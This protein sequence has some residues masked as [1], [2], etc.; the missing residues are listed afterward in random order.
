M[1]TGPSQSIPNQRRSSIAC[2]VAQGLVRGVSRSSIR[3]NNVAAGR[4]H[5]PIRDQ[6]RPGVAQVLGPGRRGGESTKNLK[7]R[8]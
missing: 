2:S 8:I 5:R 1:T 4:P 6:E 3:S 7:P